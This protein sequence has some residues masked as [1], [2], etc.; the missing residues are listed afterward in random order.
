MPAPEI[1]LAS[2]SAI[3]QQLLKNAGVVFSCQSPAVD[4]EEYKLK[5]CCLNPQEL[6]VALAELKAKSIKSPNT[7]IIGADQTLSCNGRLFNKANTLEEAKTYLQALRGETHQLHSA[8]SINL[9][10][11]TQFSTVDSAHL[12]MRNFSDHFLDNYIASSGKEIL[13]SVGCYQLEKQ[14]AQLFEKI[15]GDYF[16]ILGFPL[17]PCLAFLRQMKLLLP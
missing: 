5:H 3:R 12:T 2:T 1:I 16:T 10:G 4:E 6:A 13:S 9:A 7:I 14:G 15:E 8:I 11:E 17:L